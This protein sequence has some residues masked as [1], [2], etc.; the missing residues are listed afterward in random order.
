MRCQQCTLRIAKP[1]LWEFLHPLQYC[2]GDSCN[3]SARQRHGP[4]P[5]GP[6]TRPLSRS[7]FWI[8]QGWV[9]GEGE[10]EALTKFRLV[11]G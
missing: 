3:E 1:A 4:L 8:L 5:N 6:L 2:L 10:H 7:R 9:L 11:F